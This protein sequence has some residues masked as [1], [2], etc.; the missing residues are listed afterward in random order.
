MTLVAARR[1]SLALTR[2]GIVYKYLQQPALNIYNSRHL[3]FD[4]SVRIFHAG[5]LR[6]WSRH[7]HIMPHVKGNGVKG[8]GF[9]N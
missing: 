6:F 2:F 9:K 8:N 4:S 5:K 1:S 7:I 3:M